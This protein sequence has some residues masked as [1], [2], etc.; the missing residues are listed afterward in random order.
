M[1]NDIGA[2]K[3]AKFQEQELKRHAYDLSKL[4]NKNNEEYKKEVKKGEEVLMRI[5]DDYESKINRME[6]EVAQKITEINNRHKERMATED[7]RL[8]EELEN[9]KLGH[10]DKVREL[11]EGQENEVNNMNASHQKTLDQARQRYN[12]EKLKYQIT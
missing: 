9:L 12:N 11:R 5:R 1:N 2:L 4:K 10:Q 7:K 6:H 8:N 3:S